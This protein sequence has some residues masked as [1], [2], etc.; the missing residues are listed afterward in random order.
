MVMHM[1]LPERFKERYLP[2]VDDEGAFLACLE[3]MTPRA[4]RANT[5]KSTAREVGERFAAYGLGIRPVPWYPD[6]FISEVPEIGGTLEHFLGS[7]YLQELASMLP[8]LLVR[9]ELASASLVLDACAAPGSKTTQ[10]AA[11]MRNRGAIVAN[12]ID[13]GRIRALKFNLEKTG[14]VNTIITNQNLVHFPRHLQFDVVLV[15]APCSG[16]GTIRKSD[17]VL[18]G[19]SE[20]AIARHSR[21]QKELIVKGFDLLKPGGVLVYSTCTLAPEENEEVVDAL[22]TER[23]DA[24]LRQVSVPGFRLSPAIMEWNGTRFNGEVAKVAR[25]W[26][27]HN[28]T[29]GFFLALVGK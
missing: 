26:P 1:H 17:S 24:V 15:D 11:M 16:E 21:T 13:Y 27:H 28:D 2:V 12:D 29:D 9:D 10:M 7:I 22:L 3:T 8:P 20:A 18:A 6:A 14:T 4:F 25:V 5:L 23:K 19:W